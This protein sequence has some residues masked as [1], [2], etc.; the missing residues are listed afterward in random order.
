MSVLPSSDNSSETTLP[1][2]TQFHVV[3]SPREVKTKVYINGPGH[4]IKIAAMPI[5]GKKNSSSLVS[6]V[7]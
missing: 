7:S 5:Y 2:K 3:E 1:S 6:E 4:L